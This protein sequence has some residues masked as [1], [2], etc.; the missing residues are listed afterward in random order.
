MEWLAKRVKLH[1]RP[2]ESGCCFV[3]CAP[4]IWDAF[5]EE[6]VETTSEDFPATG[7]YLQCDSDD[8]D[9]WRAKVIV[10]SALDQHLAQAAALAT[11]GQKKA[12]KDRDPLPPSSIGLVRPNRATSCLDS[13]G[14]DVPSPDDPSRAAT[15]AP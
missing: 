7:V 5:A 6:Q 13:T 3:G 4:N 1:L 2:S 12:A 15:T 11:C 10:G 9:R 14:R 8:A